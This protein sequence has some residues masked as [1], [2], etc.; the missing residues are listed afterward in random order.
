LAGQLSQPWGPPQFAIW[1]IDQQ[2]VNTEAAAMLGLPESDQNFAS[3]ENFRRIYRDPA[4]ENLYLAAP[5]QPYRMNERLTIQQ[6]LFLCANNP[7]IGFHR[8]LK[9][10]LIH[11]Q[12][13]YGP[14]IQWLHKITMPPES[15]LHVLKA[16]NKMNINA[17]T[18]FPGLDGFARSLRTSTQVLDEAGW[19]SLGPLS[20]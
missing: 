20:F 14:G 6:G 19:P 11:G 15:R 10:L 4:P 13:R 1:A 18:L 12:Q 2:A 17:A 3:P 5:V 7:L 8:C 9:R 16:L